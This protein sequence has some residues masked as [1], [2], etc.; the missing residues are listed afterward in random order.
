MPQKIWHL[1]NCSIFDKLLPEQIDR[2]ESCSRSRVFAARRP[3]KNCADR[4]KPFGTDRQANEAYRFQLSSGRV[5]HSLP[6][7]VVNDHW[8]K[9]TAN[10]CPK[11][12]GIPYIRQNRLH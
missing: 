8:A 6:V 4:T 5:V 12:M 3:T 2:L 1:K 11:P 7:V 9:A 10:N